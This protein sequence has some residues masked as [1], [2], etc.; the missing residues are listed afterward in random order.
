MAGTSTYPPVKA[1]LVT[2]L[3]AAL[4]A[5]V[6]VSYG[7]PRGGVIPRLLLTVGPAR[8]EQEWAAQGA[9][10]RS[11]EYTIPCW[12]LVAAPGNDAQQATEQAWGYLA[13]IETVLRAQMQPGSTV[14]V[15]GSA[16]GGHL[17]GIQVGAEGQS[18]EGPRGPEGFECE[19]Q[20]QVLCTARI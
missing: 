12:L 9:K 13:T 3:R 5:D 4:P 10:G 18:F 17:V 7:F 11:E 6:V 20:F 15:A 2:A 1:A 16:T 8:F 19:I 14:Y